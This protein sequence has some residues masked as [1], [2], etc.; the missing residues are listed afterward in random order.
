MRLSTSTNIYFNRPD[1][2]KASI[3]RSIELCSI[4]GY[5]VMDLN[6]HDCATFKTPFVE[7]EC[8]WKNWMEGIQACTE[9]SK[10]EFSQAHSSFYNFCDTSLAADHR[11]QLDLLVHRSIE[12]AS[13]LG[14]PWIVM[15][16]GTNFNSARLVA[17]SKR[18]N[19]E[20]FLPLMD[21]SS[22]LGVG[23]AFENLWDLNIA[24]L[25][26]YTT[27][28]EELVDFVD[29]LGASSSELGICW[30]FE[31]ADIMGQNQQ[32]ALSL[33]GTRLKATHVSDNNGMYHDHILPFEGKTNWLEIMR[34]MESM[35]SYAGDFTYEIHRHTANLPE[36]LVPAAL[37]RSVEVGEF[38]LSLAKNPTNNHTD[39][40]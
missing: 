34:I 7:S 26:R 14:I 6:F 33:V 20:Y 37:K 12:S 2:S 27:T 4:A 30:D 36:E 39:K 18:L 3:E 10:I 28:A 21:Y 25:R 9:T 15:H 31:H 16:A 17:D 13:I 11:E 8:I 29:S 23:I 40:E 38:L 5:K 24:P 19:M 22:K 1:G 35:K 32:R